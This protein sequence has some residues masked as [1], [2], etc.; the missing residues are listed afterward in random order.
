MRSNLSS[1][2]VWDGTGHTR[3]NGGWGAA[4]RPQKPHQSLGAAAGRQVGDAGGHYGDD[5]AEDEELRRWWGWAEAVVLAQW[6]GREA[7]GDGK[8]IPAGML[9]TR[10][11][12][13]QDAD[14]GGSRGTGGYGN[15]QH[16]M[17]R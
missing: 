11:I 15:K 10:Q 7:I 9:A 8:S 4:Q 1:R 3:W 5:S 6:I 13:G 2:R 16:R 17:G 12:S 14:D